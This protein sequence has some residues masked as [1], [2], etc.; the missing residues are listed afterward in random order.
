MALQKTW[1]YSGRTIIISCIFNEI[2][3]NSCDMP[4]LNVLLRLWPPQSLST[5]LGVVAVMALLRGQFNIGWF[6]LLMPL[7][8]CFICLWRGKFCVFKLALPSFHLGCSGHLY[9]CRLFFLFTSDAC[10]YSLVTLQ[11]TT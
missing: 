5:V 8:V 6:N 9:V 3:C 7:M 1:Q 11:T 10:A 4:K 2:L